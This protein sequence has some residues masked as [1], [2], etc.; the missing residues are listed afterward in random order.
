MNKF[1]HRLG[2][3]L[4]G[5]LLTLAG[6]VQAA[7]DPAGLVSE[8]ADQLSTRLEA[9]EAEYRSNP[10]LLEKM[11]REELFPL[12]DIDYS[13]QLIL[14]RAGRG[15]SPEQLKA[16]AATTS[17]ILIDRY[18]RGLLEYRGREQI[19]VL[20]VRGELNERTTRVRTRVRLLNG[21]SIPVDYM[22]RKTDAGWK[23]FDVIVE[24]ISYVTT[25]RNQIMPQ[26]DKYGIDGVIQRLGSGDLTLSE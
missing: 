12:M 7:D 20:P 15:A 8:V 22:F 19:E 13:A 5:G 17:D 3:T 21:N 23:V 14:G 26:L 2:F 4:L 16:F 25:Y 1:L 24:G 10:E 6:P 9:N 11:V 18:A